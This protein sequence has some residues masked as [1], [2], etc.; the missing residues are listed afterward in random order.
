[1]KRFVVD[2]VIVV[3]AFCTFWGLV[4]WMVETIQPTNA[5]TY[6][7]NYV[8]DNPGIKTLLIGHSH[9]ENSINPYLMG[10]SI[11]NFAISGR[12]WIYWDVKLAERL[13]PTM[14]NLETVIFPLGYEM[15]Y[16]SPHYGTYE[17]IEELE[18]AYD[19]S[20][21]MHVYYDRL[22]KSIY[23]RSALL[24]NR[25]GPKYFK[26][27]DVD[28]LGY[29]RLNGTM[30]AEEE[31]EDETI[32]RLTE[33][34]RL[35][36]EEFRNYF[37]EMARICYDNHVRFVVVTCPCADRYMS[38]TCE[39]GLQNMYDLIDSV[40]K[41]YPVEYFDYLTDSEFRADSLYFNMTHLNVKGADALAKRVKEDIGL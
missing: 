13:I 21:Y 41:Q 19:Y 25:M 20:K 35:C 11:F 7:Y 40:Q 23:F 24:C 16:E 22:P 38:C 27:E 34:D 18:Y 5:Y 12:R 14:P 32:V 2:I 33:R 8:K 17:E 29:A 6:K 15:L 26:P 1:M 31:D 4:E 9:F 10:D 28:S 39:E 3:I 36:Y 30:R 37:T